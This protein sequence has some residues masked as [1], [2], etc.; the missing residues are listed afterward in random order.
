MSSNSYWTILNRATAKMAAAEWK[1]AALLWAQVV[2]MNLVNGSFW[3]QLATAHFNA[4][5]YRQALPAY[6]KTLELGDDFPSDIAYR[7]A[8][9][10]ALLED[11]EQA[12]V[13]LEK[14]FALGYRYLEDAQIDANLQSLHAEAR[15]RD[16]VG[17]IDVAGMSREE[18]WRYDLSFWAREVKRKG[19]DPFDK[20]SEAEFDAAI[21]ALSIEIPTLTDIQI[22]IELIKLVRHVGDGHT[23]I[24]PVERPEFLHTLP[25]K[26]YLFEEGLF[27]IA[28]DPKYQELLG[29]Q[30]HRFGERTVDEVMQA[31]DP[32]IGRDNEIWPRVRSPYLMRI[33]PILHTLGLIADAHQ[34]KLTVHTLDEQSR[35]VTL[36]TDTSEPDIWNVLPSPKTWLNLF[37]ILPKPTPLYLKRMGTHYWF[38]YLPDVNVVYCQ[39]N[40]VL[41]EPQEALTDF[42]DRLFTFIDEHD[43][44]K[45]VIDMRWNNGGNTFLVLPLVHRLIGSEKINQPG[46]LFVIIGRR[47]Y[48]AAQNTATL[49]ERH[50]SAIFV[51][52]PTGCSPNFVGEETPFRL[53]YS[54][55]LANVSDLY[56]Q[57]GWPMDFRTW[58]PPHIYVPPTFEAYRAGRDLALEAILAYPDK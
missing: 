21:R 32:L 1:E 15:F 24:L 4:Q 13:W 51:G 37:E 29:A 50:T 3:N 36:A 9:C 8:C 30:V 49:I 20:M 48:S 35:C 31:L 12:L 2:Q 38:E 42:A 6:K 54:K 27:I 7:I 39:F 57:S 5:D 43:V 11:Q 41:D 53:P 16:L 19:Y 14:A 47:T 55:L 45:L 56:W 34:V 23:W 58:I 22:I 33:L 26:F 44:K 28:T 52:E 18:G 17:M 46:K 10:Y 40:K 25:V